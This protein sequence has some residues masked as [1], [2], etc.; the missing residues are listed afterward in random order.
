MQHL[1]TLVFNVSLFPVKK[2]AIAIAAIEDYLIHPFYIYKNPSLQ[3][4]VSE[5]I[6]QWF[7]FS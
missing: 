4:C 7:Y 6:L 5:F 1:K 2:K 3:A